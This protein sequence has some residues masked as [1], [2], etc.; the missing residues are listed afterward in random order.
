[1]SQSLLYHAF[2][3]RAGYNYVRTFYENG[4]IQFLLVVRDELFLCSRCGSRHVNRKGRRFR[5]LQTVPIGFKQAW[6]VTEVPQ[7]QCLACG[8][9]FEVS[10]PLPWRMPRIRTGSKPSLRASGE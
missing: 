10:P 8:Q 6:R 3:V 9:R 7:C 1:V 2:G 4:G 5:Q